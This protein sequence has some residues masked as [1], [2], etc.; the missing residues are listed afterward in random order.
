MDMLYGGLSCGIVMGLVCGLAVCVCELMTW[1]PID[2]WCSGLEVVDLVSG[3]YVMAEFDICRLIGNF[4]CGSR[5]FERKGEGMGNTEFSHIAQGQ[6][7][8]F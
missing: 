8:D 5:W 4:H 1:W 3:R 6:H 7:K 2:C